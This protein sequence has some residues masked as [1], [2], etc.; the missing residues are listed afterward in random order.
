MKSLVEKMEEKLQSQELVR[1]T[2]AKDEI[3]SSA[4]GFYWIYTKQ[5]IKKFAECDPPSNPAHIDFSSM[6][7]IHKG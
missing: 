1:L 6:A 4:S 2:K 5:P 3:A 7:K